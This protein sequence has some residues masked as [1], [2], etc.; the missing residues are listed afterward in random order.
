M[1]LG[2]QIFLI[3]SCNSNIHNGSAFV[4]DWRRLGIPEHSQDSREDEE[5]R[6]Y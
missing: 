6:P 5:H 4:L 3:R 2:V 1:N